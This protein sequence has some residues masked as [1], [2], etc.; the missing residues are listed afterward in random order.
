MVSITL[1][2][3][4]QGESVRKVGRIARCED[5]HVVYLDGIGNEQYIAYAH[6]A[7]FEEAWDPQKE[8]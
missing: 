6:I 8:R 5:D 2:V 1:G 3:E 4:D 7:H